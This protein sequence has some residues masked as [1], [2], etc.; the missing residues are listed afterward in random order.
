MQCGSCLTWRWA[1][2]APGQ[3]HCTKTCNGLV[4]ATPSDARATT[5]D[6]VQHGRT[7]GQYVVHLC[8]LPACACV[9]ACEG[10]ARV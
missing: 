1:R 5:H 3:H 6:A 8:V 4:D 10:G 9:C 7:N 2:R